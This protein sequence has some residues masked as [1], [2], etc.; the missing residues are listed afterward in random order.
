VRTLPAGRPLRVT[1]LARAVLRWSTDG[2]RTT[3]DTE[4]ADSGLGLFLADLPTEPLPRGESVVFTFYWTDP[5]RWEGADFRI[6]V[7]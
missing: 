7:V 4:L 6:V 2:W 5:G 3:H 1:T